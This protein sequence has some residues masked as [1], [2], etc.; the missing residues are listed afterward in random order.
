MKPSVNY[1]GLLLLL[2]QFA[3]LLALMLVLFQF[4]LNKDKIE[5]AAKPATRILVYGDSNTYGSGAYGGRYPTQKQW[6]NVLQQQL[7]TTY[8]V[9]Q[10]GLNGRL[11]GYDND[12][13]Y[14]DG[15]S[16]YEGAL[17]SAYPIDYAVVALG[18]NDVKPWRDK[19]AEEIVTQ[20]LWYK[21]Y[22]EDYVRSRNEARPLKA[23]VYV[24]IVNYPEDERY[25]TDRDKIRKV[26]RLLRE[27][28]VPLVEPRDLEL[29]ADITHYSQN[30][31]ET[32]AKLV[33]DKVKEIESR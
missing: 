11:A 21:T 1:K 15:P 22:T 7:G 27:A 30:D 14:L 17:R 16:V 19:N 24:G 5:P 12:R 23:V 2:A 33:Y 9:V 29:A 18:T 28:A 8:E 10:E 32:V 25:E 20:L 6:P 26:N 31:H 4:Q 3:T 13:M